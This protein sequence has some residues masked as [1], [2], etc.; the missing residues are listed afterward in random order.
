MNMTRAI[1]FSPLA[2]AASLALLAFVSEHAS[3][4]SAGAPPVAAAEEE[5]NLADP[6]RAGV[7]WLRTRQ[8]PVTGAYGDLSTTAL[9]LRAYATCP[10]RYRAV[11][12]PFVR[13]GIEFLLSKQGEDGLFAESATATPQERTAQTRVVLVALVA[14]GD[15]S[16]KAAL[17]KA[18]AA[19]GGEAAASRDPRIPAD[20]TV[21]DLRRV[22]QT[23]LAGQ[24]APG[25]WERVPEL[26]VLMTASNVITLAELDRLLK[27]ASPAAAAPAPNLAAL[28][29]FAPIERDNALSA[30]RRG[31]E[32]LA[33]AGPDGRFGAPGRPDSG[34]SSMVLAAL[35]GVP[36]PRPEGLQRC[37][38]SGLEWIASLQKPDGSIHDGKLANYNTSAAILALSRAKHARFAETL[39]KAQAFLVQLQLDDGE[40]YSE[41]DLYYGGIGYGS[42][43]RPDLSNLQMALEALA[44]S[45]LEPNAPTYKKALKFL[46]RCQNRSESSDVRI[47]DGDVLVRAGNDGGS[48][49]APGDSKA[50][51][52]ELEGGV[53]VPRSYGSMTYALLKSLLHAGL[54]KDDPRVIAAVAWVQKHYTL[55][56]NPGFPPS[57]DPTAPYQGLFYYFHTMAQALSLVELEELVDESGKPHAWRRELCGRIVSMQSKVDGSWTNANSP[58]WMEGNPLLG[59]AYALLTLDAALPR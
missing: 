56:V 51:F 24:T 12:G 22:A 43:E 10:D 16:S 30:L 59:T 15:P 17:G 28:P 39:R 36:T 58:R 42:T 5:L 38:D 55:D 32:F 31:A 53:K 4:Q 11:D 14:L 21:K 57:R 48:A 50:G 49:Y 33:A 40:G 23:V 18:L 46:E 20:P 8:D 1:A 2:L 27:R 25:R 34:L 47:Q 45:G 52:E 3:A 19:V 29:S 44:A 37:I 41:G 26:S 35:Q 7:R 6:I 9:V 13:R 54:A